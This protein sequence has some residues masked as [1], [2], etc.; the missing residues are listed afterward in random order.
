MSRHGLPRIAILALPE[1]TA[2]V[3]H[4]ML[5]LFCSAGRDWKLVTDGEPGAPA[6]SAVIVAERAGQL[7]VTN[8][9]PVRAHA[10]LGP[11][12]YDVVCVPELSLAP[13]SSLEGRFEREIAWLK[14]QHD[15]GAIVATACSGAVLL[16]ATGLLDGLDATT[17]WAYCEALQ[18]QHPSV[19]VHRERALVAAGIGQRLVMAGGGTTWLDLALYLIAR[20]TKLETAM[21]VAKLNLIDWH[22]VGQQPYARL[23]STRQ[24]DDPLIAQC[25]DWIAQRPNV[26]APV[27][28]MVR[29]SGL[30]ER[31]FK[32]R[33]RKAAGM[34]PLEYV[35]AIRLEEAKNLL[36]TS[37][38]TL[39][40]LA[41]RV[42]YEDA[43]FFSRLFRRSVGLT[44]AQ[45]RRRFGALRGALGKR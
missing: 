2:S 8:G 17:H 18:L 25:Q 41:E 11:A 31:T 14:T 9:V 39:E 6:V 35:Q 10:D 34:S 7:E 12:T 21:Q 4:G 23:I 16:A 36:E 13:H 30:P 42:G 1:S 37:E 24:V 33:F 3:I 32:R 19:R 40:L 5:D 43:S 28:S 45:Y 44:P 26:E 22:E 20:V 15:A 27:A 29:L 38:L